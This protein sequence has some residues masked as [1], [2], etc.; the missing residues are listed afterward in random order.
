MPVD[1]QRHAA[2]SASAVGV[3]AA[4]IE[5][6]VAQRHRFQSPRST[7][8]AAPRAPSHRPSSTSVAVA[9]GGRRRAI[10]SAASRTYGPLADSPPAATSG[11]TPATSSTGD[12]RSRCRRSRTTPSTGA[13]AADARPPRRRAWRRHSVRRRSTTSRRSYEP[14][15]IGPGSRTGRR[16]AHRRPRRAASELEAA[17]LGIDRRS[18]CPRPSRSSRRGRRRRCARAGRACRPA[19]DADRRR[20]QRAPCRSRGQRAAR[21][22]RGR[23]AGDAPA[24]AGG[25]CVAQQRARPEAPSDERT[26]LGRCGAGRQRE[27]GHDR[28]GQPYSAWPSSR[29]RD[30]RR[31][32]PRRAPTATSSPVVRPAARHEQRHVAPRRDRR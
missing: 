18:P 4:R 6:A 26:Q 5:R 14:A 22:R 8:D 19:L 23:C 9:G 24:S 11:W 32:L 30:R 2:R 3:G 12:R 10:Q 13:A 25:E 27:R 7:I 28:L 1:D 20:E 15:P 29:Q 17:A 21:M 31:Q 16:R